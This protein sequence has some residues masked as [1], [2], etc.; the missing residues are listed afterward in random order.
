VEGYPLVLE[1]NTA[2]PMRLAL[3]VE[4]AAYSDVLLRFVKYLWRLCA[5]V[6]DRTTVGEVADTMGRGVGSVPRQRVGPT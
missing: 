1:V 3:R 6:D 4:S 5:G 2:Q